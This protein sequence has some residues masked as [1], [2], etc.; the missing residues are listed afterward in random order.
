MHIKLSLMKYFVKVLIK[1]DNDSSIYVLT[2]F[3]DLSNAKLK[4]IIFIGPQ[5]R[6][7]CKV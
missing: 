2:K 5:I 6:S 3:P 7:L 1:M 4:E